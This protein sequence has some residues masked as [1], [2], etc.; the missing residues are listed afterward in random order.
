MDTVREQIVYE[1]GDPTAYI[2]PDVVADFSSIR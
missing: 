1:M 2:T